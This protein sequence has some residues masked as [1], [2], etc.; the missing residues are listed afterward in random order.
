MSLCAICQLEFYPLHP[1]DWICNQC[2]HT[3]LSDIESKVEWI[4][5][6]FLHEARRRRQERRDQDEQLT[7]LGSEFDVYEKDTGRYGLAPLEEHYSEDD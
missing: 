6:C 5:V 4:R 1:R 7:Y 2:W 3:Y